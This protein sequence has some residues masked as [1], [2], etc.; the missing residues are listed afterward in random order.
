M[1][2]LT[3]FVIVLIAFTPCLDWPAFVD[4]GKSDGTTEAIGSGSGGGMPP[5]QDPRD[6]IDED[7][8]GGGAGPDS[9]RV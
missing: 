6:V 4:F 3:Y 2:L 9:T 7:G 8:P 5:Y 1:S